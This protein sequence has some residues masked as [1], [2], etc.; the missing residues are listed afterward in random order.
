MALNDTLL[1]EMRGFIESLG[2]RLVRAQLT[3]GRQRATLQIMAEPLSGAGMTLEG[4]EKIS[5]MLS[6]WLDVHEPTASAYVLEVSSPGIDRPLMILA[7]YQ[8]YV[9]FD[10]S[11]ELILP[12]AGQKRFRGTLTEVAGDTIHLNVAGSPRAFAFTA[13]KAG[14]LVMTDALIAYE[15]ARMR[16]VTPSPLLEEPA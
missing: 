9:G 7:D 13:I 5:R 12:D 10:A 8:Q 1:T 2:Y 3:S 16:A 15:S 4:C 14:K 11:I 6:P